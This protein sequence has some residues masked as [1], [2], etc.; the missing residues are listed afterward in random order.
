[1]VPQNCSVSH[2]LQ[3]IFLCVQL[4]KD[5]HMFGT[6]WGWVN[7]D[8]IIFGW[9]ISLIFI[10]EYWIVFFLV[11]TKILSSTTVNLNQLNH[12]IRMISEGSC[13]TED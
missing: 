1:M 4:N 8:A 11:Y 5:I 9:T 12:Y 6:T 10:E 3:N 7:D 2:I 13:D